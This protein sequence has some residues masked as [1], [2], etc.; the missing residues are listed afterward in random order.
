MSASPHENHRSRM[1][2][3]IRQSG[4]E[5]LPEHEQLEVMLFAVIPRANTNEIAHELL[6]RFGSIAGVLSAEES[7]LV[8]VKGVGIAVARFL[9]MQKAILGIVQRGMFGINPILSTAEDYCEYTKTLFYDKKV[10]N[11]IMIS[12]S[13]KRQV[14]CFHQLSEGTLDESPLYTQ[15][16]I[17]TALKDHAYYVILAH[18]H[19][20]GVCE[21]SHAD[22]YATRQ[23]QSAL[24]AVEI[25]LLDHVIFAEGDTYSLRKNGFMED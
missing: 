22:I 15:N 18:N 2:E 16:V 19:P 24:Q 6:A 4:L 21:P 3:K 14:I 11:C 25:I 17:K 9:H 1:D 10:E 20:G 5:Y 7:E 12:L 13:A 23:I 8:K